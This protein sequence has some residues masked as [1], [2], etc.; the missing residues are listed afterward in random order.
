[1]MPTTPVGPAPANLDL[2]AYQGVAW[3]RTLTFTQSGDPVDLTGS[4]FAAQIRKGAAAATVEET[5]TAETI[6]DDPELAA[7]EV[8]LTL[9]AEQTAAMEPGG[10]AWDLDWTDAAGDTTTPI[11]GQ[12]RVTAQVT[13]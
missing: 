3:R 12:I 8:R 9:T 2:R 13:R 5:F 1:M 11:A 7:N 10:Y 4:T 6:D